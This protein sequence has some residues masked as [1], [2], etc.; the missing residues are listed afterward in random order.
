MLIFAEDGQAPFK[1]RLQANPQDWCL[2]PGHEVPPHRVVRFP[3]GVLEIKLQESAPAWVKASV[4][5]L[6]MHASWVTLI[7]QLT[8]CTATFVLTVLLG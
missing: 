5:W 6:G 2:P 4:H 7:D 3:Y 1:H 8:I